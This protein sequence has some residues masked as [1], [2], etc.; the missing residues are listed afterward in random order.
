MIAVHHYSQLAVHQH[1]DSAYIRFIYEAFS[2]L[3]GYIGVA[4]F[5]FLSGY[6]LME[7]EKRKHLTPQQF[8]N[9]RIKRVLFPVL[10]LWIIYA[11]F[12]YLFDL[13][14]CQDEKSYQGAI[15]VLS[16]TIFS[17]GWFVTAIV[18]LYVSFS[19]FASLRHKYGNTKA[20]LTLF[21]MSIPIF[22]TTHY[23]HGPYTVWSITLFAVGVSASLYPS[24]Y[25]G[26][27]GSLKWLVLSLLIISLWIMMHHGILPV[28]AIIC[29]GIIATL[30]ITLSKWPLSLRFPAILGEASFDIYLIHK[31]LFMSHL[32]LSGNLMNFW[33]WA[34]M[35]AAIVWAFVVFR[36][37][38]WTAIFESRDT[39]KYLNEA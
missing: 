32:S 38:L 3:G 36:K 25:N 8:F 33:L 15:K 37:K 22:I 39:S 30:I 29:H 11:P 17:G 4:V 6:G 18:L 34:F 28:K 26:I 14:G 23:I 31:R 7:S 16:D 35:T 20:L 19:I 27:P 12:Y 5:F 10:L 21:A 9:K 13:N 1:I 24:S 2:V